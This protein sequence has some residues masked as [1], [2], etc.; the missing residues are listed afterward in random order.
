MLMAAFYGGVAIAC[1]GTTAVHA[2]SYPLGG[3]YH[4]PHGIANAVL[5]LPVMRFN[6]SAC[7]ERLARVYD[8]L[9]MKGAQGADE[10][11]Q[12]L[13]ERMEALLSQIGI[14][15]NLSAYGVKMDG[16]EELVQAGMGESRLLKNNKREVTPQ[17]ARAIYRQVLS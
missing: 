14:P 4:I 6:L 13:L 10:K 16:L 11:A 12:A 15:G 7:R 3:K 5:L 1:S 2:L 17:D 9:S 8:A